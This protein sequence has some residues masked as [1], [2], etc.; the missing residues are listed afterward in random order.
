MRY[1]FFGP[2]EVVCVLI[3]ALSLHLI[4]GLDWIIEWYLYLYFFTLKNL[5]MLTA[6][7]LGDFLTMVSNTDHFKALMHRSEDPFG[8]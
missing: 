7:Y 1:W 8:L 6:Y 2:G 5:D 4:F 3:Y